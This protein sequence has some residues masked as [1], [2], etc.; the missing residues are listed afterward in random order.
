MLFNFTLVPLEQVKPWG[1]PPGLREP[2]RR[3]AMDRRARLVQPAARA[4]HRRSSKLP[5]SVDGRDVR[6][7]QPGRC[8]RARRGDRGRHSGALAR[9]RAS[10]ASFGAKP[11]SLATA[12]RLGRRSRGPRGHRRLERRRLARQRYVGAEIARVQAGFVDGHSRTMSAAI[13]PPAAS[14]ITPGQPHCDSARL[15]SAAPLD[16]P[17]NMPVNSSAFRRL[18]APGSMP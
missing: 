14:S 18:R 11:R 8:R 9:T 2:C 5:P 16:M 13:A 10:P 17:M 7:R 12:D 3:A 1:A 15:P 6:S 4:V